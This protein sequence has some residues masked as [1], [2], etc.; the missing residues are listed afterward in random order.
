MKYSKQRELIEEAIKKFNVHP[1][2]DDVYAMLKPEHPNLSLGTVYRNLNLLAEFDMLHKL[3]MPNGSDRFD[4]FMNDHCHAVCSE[5]NTIFDIDSKYIIGL[6]KDISKSTGF[7][8]DSKD[9]R[10]SGIC[11]ACLQKKKQETT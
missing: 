3:N 10:I 9:I 4:G 8:L 1:T 11:D 7:I 6:K 2:A 5:C